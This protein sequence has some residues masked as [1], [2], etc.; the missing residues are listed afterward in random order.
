MLSTVP[1]SPTG[2]ESEVLTKI[3]FVGGVEKSRP[4]IA[5]HA[6][7]LAVFYRPG[8]KLQ[9]SKRTVLHSQ[10]FQISSD[11]FAE[12][13]KWKWDAPSAKTSQT[14]SRATARANL[15]G[16]LLQTD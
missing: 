9:T 11:K 2:T 10:S 4:C 15:R 3:F 14:F 12:L 13:E 5:S 8:E 6:N 16:D 1:I 7:G